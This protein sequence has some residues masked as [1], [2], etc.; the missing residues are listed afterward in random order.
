MKTSLQPL[1]L[2]AMLFFPVALFSQIPLQ[3]GK[4]A[5][6]LLPQKIDFHFRSAFL[7][8]FFYD[9]IKPIAPSLHGYSK[10]IYLSEIK[11]DDN[12]LPALCR[13][14]WKLEKAAGFPVKFRLGE[15][16]YVDWLEGKGRRLNRQ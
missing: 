12:N 11:F 5:S 6:V 14:E 2:A 10:K 9:K 3:A 13:L 4:Y 8:L 7:P 15:V 1:L 16:Q